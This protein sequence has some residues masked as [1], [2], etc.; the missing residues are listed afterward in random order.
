MPSSANLPLAAQGN[1]WGSTCQVGGGSARIC[2]LRQTFPDGRTFVG[3]GIDPQIEV[4]PTIADLRAGRDAA[5]AAA[6]K[7]IGKQ[8]APG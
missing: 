7:A 1:R 3:K 2:T 5:I 8:P 4:T 6:V